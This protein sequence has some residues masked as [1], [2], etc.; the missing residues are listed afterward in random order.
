MTRRIDP[1]DITTRDPAPALIALGWT[2]SA[3]K[4]NRWSSP[5][6]KDLSVFAGRGGDW[7]IKDFGTGKTGN[8]IIF[9]R[10]LEPSLS[11]PAALIRADDLL[12]TPATKPTT[13]AADTAINFDDDTSPASIPSLSKNP[14]SAAAAAL[15][16]AVAD[17][18]QQIGH[19]TPDQVHQKYV[20]GAEIWHPGFSIPPAFRDAGITHIGAK[21]AESFSVSSEDSARIPEILLRDDGQPELVGYE[22]RRENGRVYKLRGGRAGISI[23][24]GLHLATSVVIVDSLPDALAHDLINPQDPLRGYIAV[25]SGAEETAARLI[26]GL[27]ETGVPIARVIISTANAAPGMLTAHKIMSRLDQIEGLYLRYEP[28]GGGLRTHTDVLR[29]VL[30]STALKPVRIREDIERRIAADA[31]RHPGEYRPETAYAAE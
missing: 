17:S 8:L 1:T 22:T 14:P 25:S 21:F 31:Y 29:E 23:T 19:L 26:R 28:P 11:F 13:T 24:C 16:R 27:I 9:I 5:G 3:P 10:A 6:R 15:K 30:V 12:R 20:A 7:L 4:S 2:L 18:S